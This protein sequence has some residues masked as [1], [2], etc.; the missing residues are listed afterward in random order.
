MPDDVGCDSEETMPEEETIL[1]G[2]DDGGGDTW[3]RR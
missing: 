2:G 3:R 1:S